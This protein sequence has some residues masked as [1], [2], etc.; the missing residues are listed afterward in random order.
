MKVQRKREEMEEKCKKKGKKKKRINNVAD[1]VLMWLPHQCLFGHLYEKFHPFS[2]NNQMM[3]NVV[4]AL[5][6]SHDALC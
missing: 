2:N 4:K 6:R 3:D 5:M 1:M